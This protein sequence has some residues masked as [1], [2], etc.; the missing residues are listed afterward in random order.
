MVSID[1]IK[2]WTVPALKDYL[3]KRNLKVSGRKEELVALVFAAKM[4]P[5]LAAPATSAGVAEQQKKE[6]YGDLLKTPTGSLPDP[7]GLVQGWESEQSIISNEAS[8]HMMLQHL[9][10]FQV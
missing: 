1:D 4:M 10:Q 3:R 7:D 5:E 6:H 2:L 9:L 8:N